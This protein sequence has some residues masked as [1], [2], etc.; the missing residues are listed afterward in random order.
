MV[1]SAR[2]VLE[3]GF[4]GTGCMAICWKCAFQATLQKYCETF[5]LRNGGPG[6]EVWNH[7]PRCDCPKTFDSSHAEKK[8]THREQQKFIDID[9]TLRSVLL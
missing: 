2:K 5:L 4:R 7:V 3:N 6:I 1:I 9:I 8:E